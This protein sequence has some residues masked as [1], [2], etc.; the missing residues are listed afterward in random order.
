ME[1]YLEYLKEVGH[2]GSLEIHYGVL[3]RVVATCF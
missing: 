2:G 3:E 1:C